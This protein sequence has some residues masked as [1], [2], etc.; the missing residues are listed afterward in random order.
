MN[1]K[2]SVFLE[3]HRKQDDGLSIS[4]TAFESLKASIIAEYAAL[5]L[6]G[7]NKG[8]VPMRYV[9]VGLTVVVSDEVPEHCS[10]QRADVVVIK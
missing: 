2:G 6:D 8:V 4:A 7:F 1:F 9:K 3:M 5:L 10:T